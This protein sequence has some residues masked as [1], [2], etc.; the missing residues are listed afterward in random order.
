M[1]KNQNGVT[2]EEILAE[3]PEER[4]AEIRASS[5]LLS[6]KYQAI[7]KFRKLKE[8]QRDTL[9]S[10]KQIGLA[11]IREIEKNTD[12]ILSSF[13]EAVETNG[14]QI[15]LVLSMPD[16]IEYNLFE[17]RDWY[18]EI[19]GSPLGPYYEEEDINQ[20][21]SHDESSEVENTKQ[22]LLQDEKVLA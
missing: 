11:D 4:Q 13:R 17:L 5:K 10:S 6:A 20:A 21:N 7:I 18:E 1:T 22:V 8:Q 12:L 3:F 15:K 9:K 14:G 19:E 2:W 16:E